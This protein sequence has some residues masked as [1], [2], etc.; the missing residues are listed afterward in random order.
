MPDTAQKKILFISYDGMTDPLGQSQVIPYLQG[1]SKAGYSIFLLSCE[2]KEVFEPNRQSIQQLLDA[3]NIKWIPL[4]YTKKPPVASTLLDVFKLKKAAQKLHREYKLDMVHTRPGIPALVGLW[5][6]KK[7]GVK[8]LNDIREFYADS[9]VD[10]GMWNTKMPVYRSIYDYFKRKE[11]EAVSLSDGIV[12]LTYSAENIIKEWKEYDTSIPV[13]VIPCSADMQLFDPAAIDEDEKT[14]LKTE[15]NINKDDLVV[16]YLGSVGGWYLTDEMMQFCKKLIAEMPAVKL[17]FISPHRHEEIKLFAEK[18]GIPA[19]KI[20]IR[21][22]GRLQVPL[23]LSIS[24]YSVFFI[25]PCYSKQSSSP[26]KHGEIMA[27]GIPLITN[28]GVGDVEM[29][30]EKYQSGVV[31]KGFTNQDYTEAVKEIQAAG[32][33]NPDN[34]RQAAKEFYALE[35]AI[36][37]YISIYKRIL[38]Q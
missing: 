34:I 21:K 13:E 28:S 31:L 22:A 35:T 1:L 3:D 27:M 19:D 23:L 29:I 30:V 37:K 26:T 5:M 12:C 14:R 38:Q 10:G 6:K 24:W 33:F 32:V 2:K 20:M 17:L 8:F 25:K 18:Y 11:A 4:S 36:E 9:R 15:L 7:M 16:S